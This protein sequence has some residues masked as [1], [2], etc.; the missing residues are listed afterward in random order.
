MTQL[1][2]L[3]KQLYPDSTLPIHLSL[4]HDLHVT[5]D[6]ALSLLEHFSCRAMQIQAEQSEDVPTIPVFHH[7]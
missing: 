3:F 5:S 7:V 4:L 1:L 6:Q 2:D